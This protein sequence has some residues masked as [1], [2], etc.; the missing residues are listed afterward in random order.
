MIEKSVVNKE[1]FDFINDQDTCWASIKKLE[2]LAVCQIYYMVNDIMQ[3]MKLSAA[4][5]NPLDLSGES[6]FMKVIA[7][8][9]SVAVFQVM[10]DLMDTIRVTTPRAYESVMQRLKNIAP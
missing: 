1:F 5:S 6:D 7:G 9:D 4:E 10:D 8:K 2:P 3:M